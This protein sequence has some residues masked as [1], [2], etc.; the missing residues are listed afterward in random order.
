MEYKFKAE[1]KQI[2]DIVI[3]SLYTD[4]IIF[5]RELVS[6]ASDASEKERFAALSKGAQAPNLEIKISADEKAKTFSVEDYGIGMTREE[7]VENLGTIAHSGSKAF[8]DALKENKGGLDDSLIGQ[9]GVGFYSVFMVAD[10]V[11]VYTKSENGEG[12]HWSCDGSENFTIEPF[13]KPERGT[14]IVASLKDE[15]RQYAEKFEIEQYLKNYASFIE[16]PI[17][18]NGEKFETQQAI[19]LKPKSEVT[20]EQYESFYKFIDYAFEPPFD[21]LHFQA[22]APLEM[23]ALIYI[24]ARNNEI[25][26]MAQ[27]ENQVALYCKKI[28]IDKN[29]KNLLPEWMRFVRGVIDSS[30]IPLNISR[31]SMQNSGLTKKIG[32][33]VVKRFVKHLTEMLKK[34]PKKYDEFFKKF[35]RFVK[36]GAV[37]DNKDLQKLFRFESSLFDNGE[38]VS[39]DDY[40][41]RM[42]DSQKEIYFAYA[43]SRDAV[44]SSPYIEAFKARGIEVLYLF[45][46]VDLFAMNNLREYEG[47]P[48]KSID[49]AD[50]KLDEIPEKAD[51]SPMTAEQIDA[52]KDWIKQTLGDRVKEVATSGRLIDSPAAVLNDDP[53]TPQMRAMMRAMNPD[54]PLPKPVV[55]FEINPKNPVVKN[56]NVLREN[57][58]DLAE[59]VLRQVFDNAML[60]AGL[61]E[62][63]SD[64]SKRLNDILAHVK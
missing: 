13:D 5:I 8:L 28:L 9:F 3:N 37:S 32:N 61:L 14:K 50:I 29:P 33:V 38:F 57:S 62:S 12:L 22:D 30:D 10:K 4:K 35:G 56:L 7:L 24:P 42:K 60:C 49:S 44:N 47:K 53:I 41:G 48:F 54:A 6:N 19:W 17:S 1:V 18:I 46:P 16:F 27:Q 63:T 39:L 25:L 34:D 15:Y 64:M 23:N 26:G 58:K 21:Y 2:L 45:D 59:L 11:D 36:E 20:K 40:I 51:E 55:K 52:L 31:E 43:A